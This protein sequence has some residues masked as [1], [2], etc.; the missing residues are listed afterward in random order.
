MPSKLFKLWILASVG[1]GCAI[2][3][4]AVYLIVPSISL[5]ASIAVT[6]LWRL[7]DGQYEKERK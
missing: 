2:E 4:E 6:A 5:M 3:I 7:V 1:L